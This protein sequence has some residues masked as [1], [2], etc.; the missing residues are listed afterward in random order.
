MQSRVKSRF[1]RLLML[2]AL[3]ASS[4]AALAQGV[5]VKQGP[6]GP[7][8]SDQPTPG[9]KEVTL[10]P[11]NVMPAPPAGSKA[12]AVEGAAPGREVAPPDAMQPPVAP[13]P[14]YDRFQIISPENDG[15]TVA[16]TAVFEVRLAVDP[17]LRLADQHAFVISLNGRP[18]NQRF[19][20]TEFMVPPEF[21]E[22]LPPPNQAMQL[23]ASIIDGN[24]QVLKRA[25]PVRFY[26]R[27]A[28]VHQNP[29]YPY[30]PDRPH[31]WPPRP[32]PIPRP[33]A[34]GGDREPPPNLLE[35][36]AEPGNVIRKV[37]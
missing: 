3:G 6:N 36:P 32:R 35:A 31:V 29:N 17:P 8:F 11:L 18:V 13:S 14:D 37:R 33:P 25:D 26:L 16:N 12:P 27:Y 24:G 34:N 30:D 5:Y 22:E 4:P 2:V 28:T 1:P 21:W 7:V 15:S 19:T 23:D 10:K 20:A 9:A